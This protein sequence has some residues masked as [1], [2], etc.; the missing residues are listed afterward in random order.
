MAGP[1]ELNDRAT[2]PP[3]EDAATVALA[4][5]APAPQPAEVDSASAPAVLPRGEAAPFEASRARGVAAYRNGDLDGA[6]A[7]LDQAIQL[8]PNYAAAYIDRG[9]VFY[10]LRK[11]DRAFA[12]L[13]KAKRLDRAGHS[14]PELESIRKP[15]SPQTGTD[16]GLSQLFQRASGKQASRT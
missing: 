7:A 4:A 13:E 5:P 12:D 11:L 15:R 9:I 6:I 8:N 3:R 14:K 16:A 1:W 2:I 10:R